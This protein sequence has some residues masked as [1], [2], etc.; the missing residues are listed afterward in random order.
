LFSSSAATRS[1]R[2]EL[3]ISALGGFGWP[4]LRRQI[5]LAA[6]D[7]SVSQQCPSGVKLETILTG[8]REDDALQVDRQSYDSLDVPEFDRPFPLEYCLFLFLGV[9][10]LDL[11][12]R[13]AVAVRKLA[14][15]Y[16]LRV[17][18]RI[19]VSVYRLNY[20]NNAGHPRDF[21]ENDPAAR[22]RRQQNWLYLCHV[23][24]LP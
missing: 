4:G 6:D 9:D 5:D 1:G 18:G 17:S 2:T 7:S 16:D 3:T 22:D 20:V 21:V 14:E 13:F 15:E 12:L 11:G 24:H 10:Q 19:L 8:V 23:V